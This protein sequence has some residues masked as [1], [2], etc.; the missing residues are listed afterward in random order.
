ML[1]VSELCDFA[2]LVRLPFYAVSAVGADCGQRISSKTLAA[3]TQSQARF[4]HLAHPASGAGVLQGAIRDLHL[5]SGY[6]KLQR[7]KPRC[8]LPFDA[9]V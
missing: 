8:N 5:G 6:C 7:D 1:F 9:N 2:C 4:V 3:A